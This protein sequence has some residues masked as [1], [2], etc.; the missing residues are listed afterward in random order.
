L[1][2]RASAA[3]TR[4]LE[5]AQKF[6]PGEDAEARIER[7]AQNK[8]AWAA[9]EEGFEGLRQR[10]PEV[11]TLEGLP[12]AIDPTAPPAQ[13][14]GFTAPPA[15]PPPEI[16]EA[17]QALGKTLRQPVLRSA[18]STAQRTGLIGDMPDLGQPSF[19]KLQDVKEALD[20]A[21]SSAFRQGKGN[22][23]TRL[24][25]S[26]QAV[27][28]ALSEHVPGY[29]EVA[30]KYRQFNAHE[31]AIEIGRG[32]FRAPKIAPMRKAFESLSPA[33]RKEARLGMASEFLGWLE[34]RSIGAGRDMSTT[35][36][37]ASQKFSAKMRMMFGSQRKFEQFMRET[38]LDAEL[39]RMQQALRGAETAIR[40][41]QR[42]DVAAQ[43]VS[44]AIAPVGN[45]V[46]RIGRYIASTVGHNVDRMAS[47]RLGESMLTQGSD[48]IQQFLTRLQQP[49]PAAPPWLNATTPTALP[50]LLNLIGGQR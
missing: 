7:I 36:A 47:E 41:S 20:D 24:R 15:P 38:G 37:E 1:R 43:G 49:N 5:R 45:P 4:T 31:E 50:G 10:Y 18:W 29:A 30:A 35:V 26:R 17:A 6:L 33:L 21:V 14:I 32:L 16:A 11:E 8:R 13:Q 2:P 34:G 12:D 28:D 22:L 9:S 42:G 19:Q 23:G 44:A 3:K 40:T 25:E 39:A 48:P 46:S 27:I